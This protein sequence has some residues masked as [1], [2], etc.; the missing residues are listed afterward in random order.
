MGKFGTREKIILGVMAIAILYAAF[1]FLY[2]KAKDSPAVSTQKAMEQKTA[3]LNKFVANLNA[4]LDRDWMKNVG[5]LIFSRAESPWR[6]DPFLDGRSYRAWL[7]LK[8]TAKEVKAPPPKIDFVYSGYVAA[9]QK[10]MGIINGIEYQEGQPLEI[11]GYV[12]KSIN[13]ETAVIEN[14][15][16]GATETVPLQE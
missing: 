9:G 1:E 3:D 15:L 5:T 13:A 7:K 8:E 10:R 11:K 6:Q 4:S 16:T 14:S 12:L 2:P